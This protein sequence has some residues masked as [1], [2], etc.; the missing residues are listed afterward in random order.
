MK[1]FRVIILLVVLLGLLLPS[2]VYAASAKDDRVV[3]GGSFVLE[4]DQTLNGNLIVIGG[5]A[6]IE[7]DAVVNGSIML[8]GGQVTVDGIVEGSITLF[9]GSASLHDSSIILGDIY[10]TSSVLNRSDLADIR[11]E[12]IQG[13]PLPSGFSIPDQV[14]PPDPVTPGPMGKLASFLGGLLSIFFF[15]LVSASIAI[16][17][18]LFMPG[19]I[20]RVSDAIVSSPLIGFGTSILTL[21]ALPFILVI[22]VITIILS[23]V[24]ILLIVAIAL[25]CYLGWVA[26][27]MELGK[28]IAGLFKTVWP[29]P[30]SA[31]MGTLI[32]S[33]VLGVVSLIP[34]LGWVIV[35]IVVMIGLGGVL[36]SRFGTRSYTSTFLKPITT[37]KPAVSGPS[38]P[39]NPAV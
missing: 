13:K 9:G 11:G 14:T 10:V 22:L 15:S 8:V 27:G 6:K 37:D 23:P 4:R 1:S 31:G 34:C 39:T 7:K 29:V 32:L 12:V 36:L 19:A 20:Q 2:P 18:S 33:L 38:D 17:A 28:R 21:I 30:I 35:T 3:M 5:T 16:I 26:L 24:A 25:A